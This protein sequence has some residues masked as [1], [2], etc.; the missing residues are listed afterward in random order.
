[1]RANPTNRGLVTGID[2][3]NIFDEYADRDLDAVSDA[4]IYREV[5]AII[6]RPPR[7]GLT[8]FT[9]H[10]PLELMARYG[11]LPLVE[12]KERSLARLQMVA[13]ASAY[14][15]GVNPVEAPARIQSFPSLS[16]A[17]K[18]FTHT[19]QNGDADGLE[20]L[21][22]QIA[23]QFGTASLVHLLTPLALP[24]LTGAS[25]SHIGLWLLLRHGR[26]GE[27][28]DA[29]LLRAAVRNLARDPKLQLSSFSGM[30]ISGSKPLQQAPA[31]IE[32]EILEKLTNPTR[33]ERS[34]LRAGLRSFLEAGE[35]TGNADT[36]FADLIRCD[37]T[38]EQMDGAFQAVLRVSAHSML[39]D[40]LDRSKYGWSHCLTLPQAACGLSSL[41]M[42]RKL[43]LAS[44][45]VWI[46]AY[47][48]VGSERALDFAWIPKKVDESV[49]ILEALQTSPKVAAARVWHA[50]ESELPL[51]RRTLATQA[52]IRNDQHLAKYTR[53]CIDMG[54]FD[55]MYT[56]LYLAAAAHLCAH[57]IQE[58]PRDKIIDNL[59]EGRDTPD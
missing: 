10:A 8:S 42:N 14:E 21:V 43:A 19:F 49:S 22:L 35:K 25:H 34:P 44:T 56:Q 47:R 41:N 29:A 2:P 45:L 28:G 20:A 30:A 46:T 26:V 17:R 38:H 59:L 36:L 53:A 4:D 18:E 52:S 48:S 1:M 24:T 57:W 3:Q 16:A 32:K 6:S 54:S 51:V 11:L 39:Q 58:R 13:T 37:L 50:D 55:P 27:A 7:K 12:P 5:A 31:Q 23:A 33:E 15:S 9:L 40:D